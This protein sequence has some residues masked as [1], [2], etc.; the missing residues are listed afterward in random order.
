MK[1]RRS[2][3]LLLCVFLLAFSLAPATR[4]QDT[5]GLDGISAEYHDMLNLFYRPLDPHD[6]LHAGWSSLSSDATRRGVSPPGPLPTLPDDPEAAFDTF[7]GAYATYVAGLPSGLSPSTAAADVE[8]GMADSVHEQH[9]HY[10]PANIMRAFLSTVGGGQQSVGLGV[11]LGADPAGLITEVAPGGP[12]ANAGLQAGDVIVAADGRDL[13]AADTPS[14]AAALVGPDG[15]TVTVTVDRRNGRQNFEVT[16]GPYYFPPLESIVLPSGVGYLRLSDFVISGTTLP[17]G[18]ELLS[19]LDRRLDDL[20][21]QGVRGLVL[22]LRNNGGGSVQTADEILGRFLPD[23]VRSVRESDERGHDTFELAAGRIHARQLPMAVLINGGSASASEVTA[24][25]LRDSSR[26]ILVGQKTAGAV[27]SSELLPLPGGA[28]LQVAV[29]AATAPGSNTALDGVGITPDVAA[30]QSRTLEDYRNGRD[31]QLDA[32]VGA[33]AN[34]PPPP[35]ILL[36]PAIISPSDLDQLLEGALPTGSDLPTN[37]RLTVTARWQRLDYTHPN[38]LIDQNGGAPD[39]VALQLT[40]RGRGYQ[41]SVMASYGNTPGDLPTVSINADIY[42]GP[43]G[44]HLAASSNDL[45]Q[46]Q[47]DMDAPVQLGDETKAYRGAWLATGS[48]LLVW[49]RGRVVYTVA[50]SDVPGLDRPDTLVAISQLVDSRA[51][52]LAIP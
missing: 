41:G 26:V 3:A 37:D 32:A 46:M 17:N 48:E 40:M 43:D 35:H 5:P 38:E 10:L 12:A 18:S 25:A 15:S 28:G 7:A 31:P 33:L 47:A 23:T 51:Q 45:P 39:P 27:A 13:S 16:R 49:R 29:A 6:L 52:Q 19:D 44:A 30:S 34:A 11:R 24:A 9:T 14:L 1:P 50:Y 20:D 8:S 22:D 36:P 42:A 2:I 4:A 21:A